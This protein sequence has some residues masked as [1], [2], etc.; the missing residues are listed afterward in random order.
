MYCFW[1][2][3]YHFNLFKNERLLVRMRMN[4]FS[5]TLKLKVSQRKKKYRIIRLKKKKKKEKKRKEKNIWQRKREILLFE[6]FWS[7][8]NQ[9]KKRIKWMTGF[10]IDVIVMTIII[11]FFHHQ[12]NMD[13]FCLVSWGEHLKSSWDFKKKRSNV[14]MK[15]KIKKE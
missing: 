12:N 15:N 5:S 1:H 4:Y 8:N 13:C 10:G 11:I 9:W 6:I 7:N 14:F 3:L 2:Y